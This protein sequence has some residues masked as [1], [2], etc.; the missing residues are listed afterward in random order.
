MDEGDSTHAT[1]PTRNN[2]VTPFQELQG[3]SWLDLTTYPVKLLE[4][5]IEEKKFSSS[6][7]RSEG[8]KDKGDDGIGH[9][10]EKI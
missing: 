10:L 4:T 3:Y 6:S 5:A 2:G 9:G 1:Y 7:P 8:G